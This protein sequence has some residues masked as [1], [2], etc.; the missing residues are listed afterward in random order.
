MSNSVPKSASLKL[1]CFLANKDMLMN[2]RSFF[3]PSKPLW[4][5]KHITCLNKMSFF[6]KVKK[7]N[8]VLHIRE[9]WVLQIKCHW[10]KSC[11]VNPKNASLYTLIFIMSKVCI[12]VPFVKLFH[13]LFL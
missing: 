9:H 8:L 13:P 1:L 2:Q 12:F 11:V 7:C 3:L 10:N 6:F 5:N 4:Y